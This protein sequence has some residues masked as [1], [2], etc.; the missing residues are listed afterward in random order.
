MISHKKQANSGFCDSSNRVNKAK[1]IIAVLNEKLNSDLKNCTILDIGT[2][3]GE[4]ANYIGTI[5]K[6]V[7]S[8][9]ISDN[10]ITKENF[11]FL[12]CNENL[13]FTDQFF[14]IIIS[15]HVIEHVNNNKLHLSEIKRVLKQDGIVYLAT[16]NRLW[17]WEMHY[18]LALL[19]Y[20]PKNLFIKILKK[21]N[22]YHEDLSLLF[23]SQLKEL[24][25][26]D[27]IL[28]IFCDRI[29]RKPDN[30]HIKINKNILILLKL[31]PLKLYTLST[32]INP[33]FII[34]LRKK[35]KN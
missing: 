34:T 25:H 23:W 26:K 1:K 2:G 19:H 15:N 13:P 29:A 35:T 17:P 32:F 9:D 20:L 4:I 5:A 16:P 6:Q 18:Q 30:Y 27:Y 22:I 33:T 10:C 7:I 31:L 12:I 21:L 24:T 3:N 28:T 14:D 11:G 8:I